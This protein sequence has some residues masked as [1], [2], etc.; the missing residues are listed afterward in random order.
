MLWIVRAPNETGE[1]GS[2][3]DFA[4]QNYSVMKDI[5]E[6]IHS[7]VGFLDARQGAVF[8]YD[9][10]SMGI[11][12]DGNAYFGLCETDILRVFTPEIWSQRI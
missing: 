4:K 11:I 12:S 9:K 5:A 7:P 1:E 10:D 3:Q 8:V 2:I 6:S